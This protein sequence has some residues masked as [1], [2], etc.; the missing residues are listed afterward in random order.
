MELR[1]HNDRNQMLGIFEAARIVP[2]PDHDQVIDVRKL[3]LGPNVAINY[4]QPLQIVKGKGCYLYDQNGVEYLDCVNNVAHVGH[5]HPEVTAAVCEQLQTLNTNSRYLHPNLTMYIK[6]L[7]QTLPPALETLYFGNSGSEANDLALRVALEARPGATH[8]AVLAG[9]YH[10]HVE[11]LIGFSPY[12]FWGKG[13]RGKPKNVHVMPCPDPYRGLNLDGRRCARA[14]LEAARQAGGRICAFYCESILSCGGQIV[15]PEG[16]LKDVF[17]ELRKEGVICISDEVQCGFGRVGE[18]FWAFQS[19]GVCPDMVSIG[20]SIANGYPV[21]TLAMTRKLAQDFSRAG[22]QYFNTFGA[23]TAACA[24]ALATLRVVKEEKLQEHAA[25]VG[26]YLQSELRKIQE[27]FAMIGDVRGLGLMMG[28][29]VVQCK[30]S[31][32]VAPRLAT[33]ILERMKARRI[34][35]ST[36][37]PYDNVL[38]IKPPM[39]FGR[40]E[41]DTLVSNLRAV[42]SVELTPSVFDKILIEEQKHAIDIV[43]PRKAIYDENERRLYAG[44]LA[45]DHYGHL[46]SSGAAAAT[47]PAGFA[48][49]LPQ[50]SMNLLEAPMQR[51]TV[52]IES[53]SEAAASQPPMSRL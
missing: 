4:A 48:R 35:M 31:K 27:D 43:H 11:S 32:V 25:Q 33:W 12:K 18:T 15:P 5:C 7:L 34:L 13:G 42:L 28:I 30:K 53:L 9:A 37:G 10:G 50:H 17:D 45:A 21:S 19:Q 38:K 22:M 52:E 2:R 44:L 41:V 51:H 46:S 3:H 26:P 39:M 16:W 40:K 23:G 49:P 14:V 24:A 36:D 20:K 47:S 1:S 6:E 29:E 8:V